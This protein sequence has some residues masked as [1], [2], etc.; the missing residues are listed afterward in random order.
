MAGQVS[1]QAPQ[2][3][4]PGS[5]QEESKSMVEKARRHLPLVPLIRRAVGRPYL[6]MAAVVLVLGALW[7]TRLA[8]QEFLLIDRLIN[9]YTNDAQI[10]MDAYPIKA[11]V[12]AEVLEV[13]V[14]EG[15]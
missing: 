5:R 13:L 12:K 8:L 1:S 4:R 7:F 11:G 14:K 2:G 10:K 6:L 3:P 9:V 15:E